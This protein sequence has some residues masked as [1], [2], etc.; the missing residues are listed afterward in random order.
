MISRR[1]EFPVLGNEVRR[2]S[3]KPSVHGVRLGVIGFAFVLL[4]F[5]APVGPG[6]S[7]S[8]PSASQMAAFMDYIAGLLLTCAAFILPLVRSTDALEYERS[9]G[10][11]SVLLLANT[12]PVDVVLA[13]AAGVLLESASLLLTVLPLCAMGAYFGGTSGIDILWTL[14]WFSSYSILVTCLGLYSSTTA[15][16]PLAARV[17]AVGLLLLFVLLCRAFHWSLTQWMAAY[18]SWWL[19]EDVLGVSPAV[20]F[21]FGTGMAV[22]ALGS[23][24]AHLPLQSMPRPVA[25]PRR[26]KRALRTFAGEPPIEPLIRSGCEGVVFGGSGYAIIYIVIGITAAI[27]F[28]PRI[29]ILI[30]G[31]L[32]YWEIVSSLQRFAQSDGLDEVRLAPGSNRELGRAVFSVVFAAGWPYFVGMVSGRFFYEI[33]TPLNNNYFVVLQTP[34]LLI[35][36]GLSLVCHYTLVVV[37]AAYWCVAHGRRRYAGA[38]LYIALH[39]VA[40]GLNLFPLRLLPSDLQTGP[41]ASNDPSFAFLPSLLLLLC[42]IG[43]ALRLGARWRADLTP[44]PWGGILRAPQ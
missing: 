21:S 30:A 11:L 8:G 15:A 37:L 17:R 25:P 1:L 40:R 7:L 22:V 27:S 19:S 3:R 33:L 9:N 18:G 41:Y 12:N 35:G 39:E 44:K 5:R 32:L 16:T 13:K 36:V 29:G 23:A 26:K 28:I 24:I 10:T 31:L 4:L 42:A 2:L 34:S 14:V 38:F 20:M 43:F 6:S